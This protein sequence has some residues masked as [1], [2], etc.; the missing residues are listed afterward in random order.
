M[1]TRSED[2]EEAGDS[3]AT[4]SEAAHSEAAHS[5]EAWRCLASYSRE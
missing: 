1:E 4:H 2:A 3:E 5:E